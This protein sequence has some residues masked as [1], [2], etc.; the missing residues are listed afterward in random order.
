MGTHKL[1]APPTSDS[2]GPHVSW[3]A[4]SQ[5]LTTCQQII[6]SNYTGNAH[7]GY[8]IAL[9]VLNR[10]AQ[11][12]TPISGIVSVK[13]C[14]NSTDRLSSLGWYSTGRSGSPLPDLQAI[15]HLTIVEH[16]DCSEVLNGIPSFGAVCAITNLKA[17]AECEYAWLLPFVK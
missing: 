15:R 16:A 9:L 11:H 17:V 1:I 14:R 8:D 6:H 13:E 10:K 5:I 4:N 3:L 7:D 2:Q 12:Y